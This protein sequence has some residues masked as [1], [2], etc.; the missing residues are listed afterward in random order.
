M[1]FIDIGLVYIRGWVGGARGWDGW[2]Q[3]LNQ[4]GNNYDTNSRVQS[5]YDV[6]LL[7]Q[8]TNIPL[9]G[10]DRH[11]LTVEVISGPHSEIE[12]LLW[13][14]YTIVDLHGRQKAFRES[15]PVDFSQWRQ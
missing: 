1:E 12:A 8:R 5:N 2:W 15:R 14:H 11:A 10:L 7:P 9:Q 13:H 3:K 6:Y 4:R